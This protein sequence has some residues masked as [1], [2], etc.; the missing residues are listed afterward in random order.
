MNMRSALRFV[1]VLTPILCVLVVHAQGIQLHAVQVPNDISFWKKAGF[2]EMTPP[3]RL[4]TDKSI[5]DFIQVWLK[6]PD[7]RKI[8]VDWL[9][10]Q[11]RLTLKFPPGTVADR[12]EIMKNAP[13]AMQVIN[14]IEDVRGLGL[15][16]TE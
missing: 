1:L 10:D 16:A 4:P 13:H 3:M 11:K 6:V 12:V 14:G 7:D 9:K 2:A 8:I 15:A 5:E